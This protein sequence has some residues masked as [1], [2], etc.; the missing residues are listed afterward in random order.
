MKMRQ[1][2]PV[3][4]HLLDIHKALAPTGKGRETRVR[5]VDVFLRGV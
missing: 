2:K 1:M 3:V 4:W 5:L